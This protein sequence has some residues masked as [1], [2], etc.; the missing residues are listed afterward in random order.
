MLFRKEKKAEPP[1]AATAQT[2]VIDDEAAN[3][4]M[5]TLTAT[6]TVPQ[7]EYPKGI[8]LVLLL[9]SVFLT[10]F[11]VALDRLIIATAIPEITNEFNSLP[12]VGWYGSAYLLTTCSFQL[13]FGKLYTFFAVKGVWLTSIFIFEVGSAICGAAPNSTAFII[14]RAIQGIGGAGIFSG[15]I[16]KIFTP[17]LHLLL[18]DAHLTNILCSRHRLRRAS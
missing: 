18:L 12:D 1:A 9:A 13:L 11:L 4:M 3:D 15:A 16:G 14:G 17:F 7:H 2:E 6:S 10:M 5:P 8:Q